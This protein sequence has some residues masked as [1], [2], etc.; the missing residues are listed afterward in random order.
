MPSGYTGVAHIILHDY[1]FLNY[2]VPHEET[3]Q[4]H[5]TTK[6]EFWDLGGGDSMVSLA[7]PGAGMNILCEFS[8]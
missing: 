7:N 6:Y 4:P 3:K 1:N 2:G 8:P 5:S